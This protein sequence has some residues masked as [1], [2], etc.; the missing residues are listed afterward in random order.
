MIT[1]D[2][3]DN[4]VQLPQSKRPQSDAPLEV[5]RSTKCQHGQFLVDEKLAEIECGLC[6]EKLNP[7][8]VLVRLANDE[9]RL[10][11]R[12]ALLKADLRLMGERTRCKCKHCGQMTP[13]N[14]NVSAFERDTL[15]RKI[16]AGEVE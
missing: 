14:S 5:V 13:I 1:D 4:I 3:A 8:W 10:R 6:H 16:L 12:W 9:W 15:A 2:P 11:D 7:M